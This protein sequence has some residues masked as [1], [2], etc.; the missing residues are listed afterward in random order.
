MTPEHDTQG[1]EDGHQATPSHDVDGF[2]APPDRFTSF[3]PA[4]RGKAL[5]PAHESPPIP[6]IAATSAAPR[7]R[8]PRSPRR[9]PSSRSARSWA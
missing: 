3:V 6:G 7:G 8:G 5:G 1:Q 2:D 9:P 4:S